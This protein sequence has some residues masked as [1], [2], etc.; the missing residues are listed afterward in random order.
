MTKQTVSDESIRDRVR[1][2]LFGEY[3]D[4]GEDSNL[5]NET[6]LITGGILDSIATV[7]LVVELE[8][9]YNLSFEAHDVT[10]DNFDTISKIIGLI[11]QKM[12][13]Q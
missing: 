3:L 5:T 2:F 4:S 1:S 8:E 12:S 13:G 11:R 6:P 7:R 9:E 10:V